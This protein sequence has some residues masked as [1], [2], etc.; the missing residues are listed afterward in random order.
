V[1]AVVTKTKTLTFEVPT[2]IFDV[3]QHVGKIAVAEEH[4]SSASDLETR[5]AMMSEAGIDFGCLSPSLQYERPNG[6]RDTTAVNDAIAAYLVAAPSRFPVAFGALDLVAGAAHAAAEA[7]RLGELGFA[8]VNW[9]HRYQG[10][11]LDDKRM[12]PVLDILG[13]QNMVAAVHL[14]A[15]STMENPDALERLAAAHPDVTFLALDALSG[16]AQ[17]RALLGTLE[18]CPNV[19]IDTA[20]CFGLA[21]VIDSVVAEVGAERVLFGTDLYTS[22]RMWNYPV[23]L[24]EVSASVDLTPA[25]K[26]QI[27]HGNAA[28][29][30]G[31]SLTE[32]N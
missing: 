9:H 31:L 23:G 5:T 29:L 12:H 30:F 26:A 2:P 1:G 27:V 8:G 20:G 28:R 14:F 11:M 32:E 24:M 10:L 13:E 22:P 18:R 25:Q 15:D 3:H 16:F 6:W 4:G 21:R 19:L 7:R 17:S